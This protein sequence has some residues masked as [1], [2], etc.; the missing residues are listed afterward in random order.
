M[1]S[2]D[3]ILPIRA[4]LL[5]GTL[6]E[7][8]L[9][10]KL[11]CFYSCLFC[12]TLYAMI[13]KVL[14]KTNVALLAAIVGMYLLSAIHVVCRCVIISN[15][16]IASSA[17]PATTA[18]YL[19][20]PPLGLSIA[21]ATV[22]TTNT[23]IADCVLIW[24]CWVVWN[25]NWKIIVLPLICTCVGAG[26]GYKSIHEQ[27]A[28]IINPNLDRNKY[29]DYGTPYFALSLVTTSLATIF[30][31][32]RIITMTDPAARKARGYT[33]AIEIMVESAALYSISLIVFLPFLVQKASFDSGY[34][35]AFITQLTGICPTLIVARVSFGHARPDETWRGRRASVEFASSFPLRTTH[36]N[37]SS[38]AAMESSTTMG[39]SK[40]EGMEKTKWGGS[41]TL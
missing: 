20:Q 21:G 10:G 26:L 14:H 29:V 15:A 33:R 36:A 27:A 13:F 31:V 37:H 18:V 39:E 30:I 5:H 12:M 1:S 3:E 25:R 34:P 11:L 22:S 9:H 41:G 19:I 35:Q 7:V 17:S 8:L 6:I 16:F 4:V 40:S 32:F 2:I 28:Y 23:L 24:R 38:L